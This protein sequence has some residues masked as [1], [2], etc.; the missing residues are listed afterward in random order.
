MESNDRMLPFDDKQFMNELKQ[1]V[2]DGNEI[3]FDKLIK[4]NLEFTTSR[5]YTSV[6]ED[7]ETILHVAV[8][9]N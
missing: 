2:S 9:F 1:V 6:Y 4:D 8:K 5:V 7:G 3:T